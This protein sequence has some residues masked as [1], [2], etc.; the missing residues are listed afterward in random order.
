[1]K[2]YTRK[3]TTAYPWELPHAALPI[4]EGPWA[5]GTPAKVGLLG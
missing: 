5:A 3:I 1:M 2:F 4:M